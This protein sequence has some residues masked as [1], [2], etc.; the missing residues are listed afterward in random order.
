MARSSGRSWAL[1]PEPCPQSGSPRICPRKQ[2][3]GGELERTASVW[4]LSPAEWFATLQDSSLGKTWEDAANAMGPMPESLGK[5]CSQ[6]YIVPGS[7]DNI[8]Q[9]HASAAACTA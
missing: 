3:A 1:R 7:A 5:V 8:L 2:S 9:L 6:T 4:D